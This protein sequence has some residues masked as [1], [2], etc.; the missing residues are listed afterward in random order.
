MP[1]DAP[2]AAPTRTKTEYAILR[3]KAGDGEDSAIVYEPVVAGIKANSSD[4]A[5]RIWAERTKG[6]ASTGTYVAIPHRS[7]RPTKIEF[8]QTT[9][10]KVG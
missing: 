2:A 7:F 3:E 1:T 8:E 9:V 6:T 5:L 4:H 10:V